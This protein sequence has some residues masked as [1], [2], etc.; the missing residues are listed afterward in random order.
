MLKEK[1]NFSLQMQSIKFDLECLYFSR[2]STQDYLQY[3]C[4]LVLGAC[5]TLC[6]LVLNLLQFGLNKHI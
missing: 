4:F 5:S 1:E 6:A 2:I 3:F